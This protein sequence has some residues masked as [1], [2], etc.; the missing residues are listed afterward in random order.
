MN[1]GPAGTPSSRV[2]NLRAPYGGKG[3]RKQGRKALLRTNATESHQPHV[4]LVVALI[5]EYVPMRLT[6]SKA[7]LFLIFIGL[8]SCSDGGG[9]TTNLSATTANAPPT[10]AQANLD[11]TATVGFSFQYD[12]TQGG[13]AF[14]DADGDA[15]TYAASFTPD[16][17]GLS[18]TNGV[19]SGT[20]SSAAAPNITVTITAT[21][22]SG[23]S[24]SDQFDINVSIDQD[25]LLTAF[26]GAIDLSALENYANPTIP[27]YIT[28]F[29]DG[30]NP[31]TNAGATLGRILFYDK[32]L[33]IDDTVSCA[34]CHIQSLAFSDSAIVSTGVEGGQ[35]GRHSMRLINTQ[36][37]DETNF[38]W[39]E[40][41]PSHEAQESQPIQDHNE[42]GF[43]G[44]GGRPDLNDLIAKLEA[45]EVYNEIFRFVFLDTDIT[46]ERLQLALA[47]FVKSIHSFDARYDT[48]RAQVNNDNM[49]FP[50][51]SADENAGKALFTQLRNN[52]GAGCASCHRPPEFDIAPNSDHNGIVGVA[53]N[54]TASDLTNTRSP[55]LRDLLNTSG[56]SNGPFMH[57]GSLATL[58]TVIDHYDDIQIPAT[59]N[60]TDFLNT[61]DNRLTQGGNPQMLNLTNTEKDQIIAFL[62]TLSGSNVYTDPKWSD[63]F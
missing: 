1:D 3:P 30:G 59:V 52:G 32:R 54:P 44:Q 45:L 34:S 21:D 22:A 62:Q 49:P 20:P 24:A 51:F 19:I 47:Q 42:H 53:N 4:L 61:L 23:A 43:S 35:T 50:N 63:P 40:R 48:G 33:S 39:N 58:Q 27:N 25:A 18:A 31:V 37:A 6:Y 17:G 8:A 5:T 10:L 28:K 41:A 57:D 2:V 7:S 55:T 14:Q 13:A 29:N 15:L 16:S 9:D 60:V 56:G 46:E 26:G 36:Y 12:A 11:Q 38:F